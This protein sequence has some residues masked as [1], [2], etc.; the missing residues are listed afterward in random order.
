MPTKL[1]EILAATR[2]R[3]AA[4]KA[5]GDLTDALLSPSATSLADFATRLQTRLADR[6]RHHR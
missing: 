4:A 3:V 1:E 6:P 2:A 5:V